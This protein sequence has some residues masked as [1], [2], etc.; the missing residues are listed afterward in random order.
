MHAFMRNA[1]QPVNTNSSPATLVRLPA[2]R[3][4][5]AL[6]LVAFSPLSAEEA[7]SGI[8]WS[9]GGLAF[10]DIY[11]IPSHHSEE[12]EGASGAV[13]RR[14]YLTLDV[15]FNENWFGRF[16]TETNQSGE[17]ETY[18]FETEF[19]DLHVGRR[20]GDHTVLA[21]LSPTP[22][23]DIIESIWG[24][25]YLMRTPMDLQGVASRDTG[26]SAR[27][28]LNSDGTLGYRAMVGAGIE[29]G[30][31]SGDGRKWMT[32][33][34]WK[35]TPAWTL[36]AYIDYE[37][38]E[39]PTDRTTWQLFAGYETAGLRWGAQYS[40][41]DRE[42]DPALELASA[43]VVGR[44]SEKMNLVARVDRIIEPS[45]LGDNISYIPFDPSA[46]ATML[47]GGI[48]LR[49]TDTFTL[50]P[51]IISTRYDRNE[52]GIRPT[53]DLHLRLTFFLDL[54]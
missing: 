37:R 26:L 6:L 31:E 10:G 16:R 4:A 27:G 22:T 45:P 48:E 7:R 18:S 12:G 44:L 3:A 46:P 36:D 53:Q 52:D 38:L 13:L 21:G 39:G 28:P 9:F 23:F 54:E 29:F 1:D 2:I 51:N 19:K 32:A 5:F 47:I 50:T 25:R 17:F 11:T 40:S 20:I 41:Q 24:L 43:F 49:I 8:E 42:D 15:D 35:P 34:T 30:N 33:M 14:M